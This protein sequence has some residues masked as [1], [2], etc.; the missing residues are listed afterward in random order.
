MPHACTFIRFQYHDMLMLC[1][2]YLYFIF[3]TCY[4]RNRRRAISKEI[5][6]FGSPK[7]SYFLTYQQFFF[8]ILKNYSLS[9]RFVHLDKSEM[10]KWFS[11]SLLSC[12]NFFLIIV[13]R[14]LDKN[15]WKSAWKTPYD[16]SLIP[17]KKS[18]EISC[19]TLRAT[20]SKNCLRY[21]C[22]QFCRK[23]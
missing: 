17:R 2:K 3:V 15:S 12:F 14:F 9:Y 19:G 23:P 11:K 16:T 7:L 8:G 10:K 1:N 5:V 4:T 22:K 18:S 13:E 21:F 20:L 6:N